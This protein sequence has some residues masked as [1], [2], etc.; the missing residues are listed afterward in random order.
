MLWFLLGHALKAVMNEDEGD[1]GRRNGNAMYKW[2]LHVRNESNMRVKS[3][4]TNQNERGA[5][6]QKKKKKKKAQMAKCRGQIR[7][8][9]KVYHPWGLHLCRRGS[10]CRR[11]RC[12]CVHCSEEQ[13]NTPVTVSTGKPRAPATA[14]RFHSYRKT[15]GKIL[16]VKESKWKQTLRYW[17]IL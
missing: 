14:P 7:T 12:K 17:R 4:K 5:S 1:D 8:P 9:K 15:V 11:W 6:T 16:P 13:R 10:G 2:S 3:S